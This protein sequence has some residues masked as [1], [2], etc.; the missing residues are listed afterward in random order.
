LLGFGANVTG[1]DLLTYL[2][3][4]A[5]AFL[6][7]RFLDAASVGVYLM[8]YNVMLMPTRRISGVLVQVAFPA[9]SVVQDDLGR[10][11]RGLLQMSSLIALAAFPMMGG[12]IVVAPE[13][14]RVLLGPN[15]KW[16]RAAFIIRV[17]SLVGALQALWAV[18]HPMFKALG[19]VA[20]Q[21]RLS[22]LTTLVVI[23]AFLIGVRW[24]IEGMAVSYALSQ[25]LLMPL[26]YYVALSLVE[27]PFS[28][29]W[30]AHRAPVAATLFMSAVVAGFRL[31]TMRWVG[32]SQL[33][34]LCLEVPLGAA[35][36][37]AFLRVISPAVFA[38]TMS[39]VRMLG[40]R[41]RASAAPVEPKVAG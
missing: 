37:A 26:W 34:L 40:N 38:D 32:L 9:F 17:L 4:N 5:D 31:A 7:G 1:Q 11:R 6:I 22:V 25:F 12:L 14:V 36:Y 29:F 18:L 23:G 39:L 10:I 33:G 19:K 35:A 3:R 27:L 30:R 15:P 8:A 24:Q 16:A 41:S 2:H 28:E 20:L 21:L 13:A